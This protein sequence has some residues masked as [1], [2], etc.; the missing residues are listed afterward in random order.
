MAIHSLGHSRSILTAYI[1]T[2]IFEKIVPSAS[3]I[4][5]YFNCILCCIKPNISSDPLNQEN[6][7]FLSTVHVS[8]SNIFFLH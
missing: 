6:V 5:M 1:C 7:A 2:Y 3:R 8:P 4:A